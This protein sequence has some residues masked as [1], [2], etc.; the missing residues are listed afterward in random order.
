M[1][2]S[3]SGVIVQ[4]LCARCIAACI[5]TCIAAVVAGC[6]SAP[7]LPAAPGTEP[8]PLLERHAARLG[9]AYRLDAARSEVRIHVFRG[10]RMARLGHNHVLAAPRLAGLAWLDDGAVDVDARTEADGV[11]FELEFRLD[12]LELDRPDQRAALAPHGGG[13]ASSLSAEA[14]AATRANMLGALRAAQHPWVRL[15]STAVAGTLPKLV[16]ELEVELHGQRRLQSVP[17]DVRRDGTTLRV[18]GTLALRQSD[19]GLEPFSVGAGLLAVRDELVVE[20]EL[21]LAR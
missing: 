17:L 14:I 12:E 6:A 5:A 9:T 16:A 2:R 10:G 15:R 7:P 4:A 3:L 21:V 11:G 13:W 8:A 1:K 19:F 20:F 18:R